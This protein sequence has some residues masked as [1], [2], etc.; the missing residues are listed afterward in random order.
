MTVSMKVQLFESTRWWSFSRSWSP[1]GYLLGVAVAGLVCPVG[2]DLF[3]DCAPGEVPVAVH[4]PLEPEFLAFEPQVL[5]RKAVV[6]LAQMVLQWMGMF[7][8]LSGWLDW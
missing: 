6:L 5:G 7:G 2:L 4:L 1:G 8:W 3:E